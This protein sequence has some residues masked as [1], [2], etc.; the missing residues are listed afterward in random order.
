[1]QLLAFGLDV[2]LGN[3]SA[4]DFSG[5][6]SGSLTARSAISQ[7]DTLKTYI[8]AFLTYFA[9]WALNV[10][11]ASALL[12]APITFGE[13]Y[14]EVRRRFGAV[15]GLIGLQTLIMLGF[16]SPLIL[17]VLVSFFG[18]PGGRGSL[19][20][21]AASCLSIF[22]V[23]YAI[24]QVR[25]QVILPAAV[26][27]ELSPRE[28]LTRSWELT[29]NYW[30]RTFALSLVVGILRTIVTLGPGALLVGL[31]STLLRFDYFTNL[32]IAQAIGIFTAVLFAPVE[33][34]SSAL[35]YFDQRVRKEGFDL[36]TAITQ[37][38]ESE[39]DPAY[40]SNDHKGS[41]YDYP[42]YGQT[43]PITVA[44]SLLAVPPP[45]DEQASPDYVA[46]SVPARNV[47]QDRDLYPL[48]ASGQH[49][50][51][52]K[53][54]TRRL[55]RIPHRKARIVNTAPGKRKVPYYP[56]PA[57]GQESDQ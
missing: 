44:P 42:A 45:P 15:L 17:V 31:A 49:D 56:K 38:Y 32:A 20:I 35:Y 36:D 16:F 52:M 40:S 24:I 28:A 50:R 25:L 22:S 2:I 8:V 41:A 12:N 48:L 57:A 43:V 9:A 23:I 1:V 10:A 4:P 47:R 21:G 14:Q 46:K 37:R 13:A 54:F 39:S 11:I 29:R 30:W 19:I 18:G 34:G 51:A 5:S 3:F 53:V 33:I 55:D 7:I 26:H 27:E 6:V